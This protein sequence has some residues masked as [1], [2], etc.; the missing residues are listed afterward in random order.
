MAGTGT[1]CAH[2]VYGRFSRARTYPVGCT[3]PT[4]PRKP[5]RRYNPQAPISKDACRPCRLRGG[6]DSHRHAPSGANSVRLRTSVRGSAFADGLRQHAPRRAQRRSS[7]LHRRLCVH[8]RRLAARRSALSSI[9]SRPGQAAGGSVSRAGP[10]CHVLDDHRQPPCL[11]VGNPGL[12]RLCL[13]H[14]RLGRKCAG[15]AARSHQQD[16]APHVPA[17]AAASAT[18]RSTTWCTTTCPP[19]SIMSSAE[20][21]RDRVNWVGHSLGGMLVFAYLEL[22][23]HPE[24]I[25]NFVGMGSTII[26]AE[27]P[28]QDMLGG[29]PRA[30]ESCRSSP[31]RDGW[32]GRWRSS[33]CPA[34]E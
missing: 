19:F 17:G 5:A 6:R 2:S 18:G 1:P 32:A 8:R 31:A 3:H 33:A 9:E 22:A 30:C 28:Q 26:Q 27:I 21:G 16:H 4:L 25:A 13:R 24:R 20:T 34:W 29:Q 15:W 7:A 14:S 11:P 12:R 23:P 10:Q